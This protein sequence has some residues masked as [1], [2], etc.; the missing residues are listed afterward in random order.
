MIDVPIINRAAARLRWVAVSIFIL[1][2]TLNYLDRA[3]LTTLAPLIMAE[4]HLDQTHFGYLI[5]AFSIAY[6]A[7]SLG[8]GWFLDRV[9]VSRGISVAVS[10]WSA[11]AISTGLVRGIGGLTVCRAALGIGESAGVPAV[12]KL[13]GFY[14]RPEERALGAALNQI[15]LSA[16][17]AIAP[18][19]IGLAT[20]RGWRMPFILT[21]ILGFAWIPLWWFTSRRIAPAFT[22]QKQF[23]TPIRNSSQW[24]L[25]RDR[26][27]LLLVLA[28]VLWMT[29]YSLWSNWTALYLMRVHGLTLQE[30]AH[31]IWIPPVVSN[32]GGFFGGWLSLK[33]MQRRVNA[34]T[35]RRRAVWFSAWGSCLTFLLLVSP[36]PAWS[37]ALISLSFF[38]ALAGSVNIYALPIDLFGPERAGLGIAALTCAFGLMQTFISPL[39]G[40]LS[41][42]RLYTQVIWIVTVPLFLSA[43]V[44]NRIRHADTPHAN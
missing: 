10:W 37:I 27:L 34:I 19:C 4:M 35:A 1:S 3:L 28:N 7:S 13:N 15:G 36:S 25:L 8:A 12:G 32:L 23:S 6:A 29:S 33:W 31:Y 11:A 22:S 16:G 43:L 21:G 26:N 2:S 41:D 40:F 24:S 42:H 14:L 44:L 9:G 20:T 18:L 38:F 30:V 5:S 39:I 17:L